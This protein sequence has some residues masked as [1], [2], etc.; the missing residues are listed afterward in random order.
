MGIPPRSFYAYPNGRR[1]RLENNEAEYEA[2][3]W[4]RNGASMGLAMLV[5]NDSLAVHQIN[6]EAEALAQLA[7]NPGADAIAD[8]TIT[9]LFA[10]LLNTRKIHANEA[11]E[12]TEMTTIIQYLENDVQPKDKVEART[13]QT[14]SARFTL[15]DGVLYKR[16]YSVPLLLC[17]SEMD[18]DYSL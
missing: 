8:E 5:H 15:V 3:W 14:Q 17:L 18:A 16:G 7:S 9:Q 12:L 6:G 13:L 1:L 11:T 10:P 2:L 4:V